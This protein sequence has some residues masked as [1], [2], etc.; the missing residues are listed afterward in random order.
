MGIH[1][2]ILHNGRIRE[3]AFPELRAGQIGLLA[4]WGIFTTLRIAGGVPFAWERH[5]ARLSRDAELLHVPM[6]ASSLEV[7]GD[8]LR[9]VEANGRP[10]CTL[11]L[12]IVRNGGGMW[13]DALSKENPIDVIALTADSKQWPSGAR[14][15]VQPNARF[16]GNE[17]AGAKILSWAQ[18]LTWAECAQ[19][20]GLD[21]T[22]LL[23]QHGN[24]AECTSANIFAVFGREVLTPPLSDG[25]LPGI[26]REV[27]LDAVRVPDVAVAER[28]LTLD[29]LYRADEVFMTSTTR[30]LLP[31]LEIAGR[32]LRCSGT[33]REDLASA[34]GAFMAADIARRRNAGVPV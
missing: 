27:L 32:S 6:P 20:R 8:L 13:E 31:V 22:V 24:V 11:R 2:Y 33:A 25:C 18:N 30:D 16:A 12:A 26:T 3:S 4:G 19:L 1:P 34:F 14:L 23:N 17:F 9:L 5:W 15:G 28:S 29:D 21:E 10:D 7:E